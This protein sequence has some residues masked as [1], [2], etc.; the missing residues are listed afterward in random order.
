M[1][2]E[3][4][5]NSN[6]CRMCLIDLK[7]TYSIKIFSDEQYVNIINNYFEIEVNMNFNKIIN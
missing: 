2:N 3:I 6:Y 1:Y 7:E 4:M 5:A